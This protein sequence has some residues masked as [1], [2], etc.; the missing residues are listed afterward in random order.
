VAAR[1]DDRLATKTYVQLL[2]YHLDRLRQ[3]EPLLA[4]L[5]A[6]NPEDPDVLMDLAA[7]AWRQGRLADA[8]TAYHEVLRL[9][10]TA[11]RA[12]LNLGNLHFE[13]GQRASG[14]ER[15]TAWQMARKAYQFYLIAARSEG[16]H[17]RLDA[18]F[19]VPYRMDLI[20]R[21]IG[22][23]DGTPPVPGQNF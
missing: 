16:L 5:K 17:D 11:T 21:A 7:L 10:A 13:R 1:P 23:D 6:E 14:A 9:D 15:S 22:V 20:A 4:R 19:A 2:L 12:A 3:A 18:E 8:V